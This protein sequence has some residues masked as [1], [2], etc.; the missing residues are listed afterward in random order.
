MG[1][2]VERELDGTI[3]AL[4]AAQ[5]AKILTR[6]EVS[7]IVRKRR[8]YEYN[9]LRNNVSRADYLHY[10]AFERQL[11]SIL[12]TRAT[13]RELRKIQVERTVNKTAARVNLIY[14]RAVQ[15]FR[16]DDDLWLH[17]A[18]HCIKTG[19]TR[20]AARVFAKAIAFRNDSERIWLAAIS[21]HFDTNGDAT[22]ARTLAQRA[23]R[24]LP[25]SLK[26]WKEYFR[27]ELCYLGKLVARR[28][29]IGLP[30][31][32]NG[33][34]EPSPDVMPSGEL[35]TKSKSN[36]DENPYSGDLE[37]GYKSSDDINGESTEKG[38]S[39]VKNQTEE[40]EKEK[41]EYSAGDA[42]PASSTE[43]D[44]GPRQGNT[45]NDAADS[46]QTRNPEERQHA[47]LTDGNEFEE[48][49]SSGE[50]SDTSSSGSE[51]GD[52]ESIN[53]ES[54]SDDAGEGFKKLTFWDGGVPFSVFR[55]VSDRLKLSHLDRA[56][57]WNVASS[58]PFVPPKL[59]S[60]MLQFMKANNT[61]CHVVQIIAIREPWDIDR[62]TRKRSLGNKVD[63]ENGEIYLR[64]S[65]KTA[66]ATHAFNVSEFLSAAVSSA[67]FAQLQDLAVVGVRSL[68]QSFIDVVS[69]TCDSVKFRD[70][71]KKA[72]SLFESH[73]AQGMHDVDEPETEEN[74]SQQDM[75]LWKH[76]KFEAILKEAEDGF[77]ADAE[78]YEALKHKLIIPFRSLEQDRLVCLYLS[79]ESD[80][81][82]V[83][84][85]I[86]A[87]LSLPPVT[88]ESLKAAI[89]AEL[90][91]HSTCGRKDTTL[92]TGQIDQLLVRHT[93]QLFKKAVLLPAAKRDVDLW[94]SY[95]DF[96]RSVAGDMLEASKANWKATKVLM[97]SFQE[98]FTERQTLRNLAH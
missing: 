40:R 84:S 86:S 31:G 47:T 59:L 68:L 73:Q 49:N 15:K 67:Q 60:Q 1:D 34:S 7:D 56:D 64:E 23:L 51:E 24:A 62:T 46:G 76:S 14:S 88:M 95:V 93:R 71:M 52:E 37:S 96:E 43:F 78:L 29:V 81:C 39:S 20:A 82:R 17:Y 10:A 16:F 83:R 2:T 70:A 12:R 33:G 30:P 79:K 9:L 63:E 36:S 44:K 58:T 66:L 92:S 21:F 77:K 8:N 72:M 6:T 50:E 25:S 11:S 18:K 80:I 32:A 4:R 87:I 5:K 27:L 28:L 38:A 53:L 57:F 90:R 65:D 55:N 19:S 74:P 54:S 75:K 94:L 22:G 91:V 69:D 89:N 45:E 3:P 35:D 41:K 48:A 42:H 61:G 98:T 97:P 13:Q 85:F 26:L